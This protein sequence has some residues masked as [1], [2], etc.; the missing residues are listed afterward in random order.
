A[1]AAIL[2]CC[3]F[4]IGTGW[5]DGA[6]APLMAAVGCSFF[7]SQD[8]PAVG[9]RQFGVWAVVGTIVV[10]VYLFAV[11]PLISTAEPLIVVL[12]P[13]FILFAYLM[14]R[15]T[16]TPI[17]LSLGVNSSTLLALQST[18]DADFAAFVNSSIAFNLGLVA[19]IVVMRT[20]RSVGAEWIAQR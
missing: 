20:A 18:Y 12:A 11:L 4:W 7:A 9:I 6:S 10:A 5:P 2:L 3:A 15:P 19:A 8:D 1:A 16:T 13:A 17:G 14:A